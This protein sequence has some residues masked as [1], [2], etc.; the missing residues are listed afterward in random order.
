MKF[1]QKEAS[2]IIALID[3]R[4]ASVEMMRGFR[5]RTTAEKKRDEFYDEL[6]KKVELLSVK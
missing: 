1:N 6:I 4:K 3:G 2:L 5:R